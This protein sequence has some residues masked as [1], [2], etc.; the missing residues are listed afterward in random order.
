MA[1]WN[2]ALRFGLEV[3]AVVA[4]G[5]AAW[6]TSSSPVRW[7]AVVAIP[8]IAVTSWGVFNVVGDPSRSGRAPVEVPGWLRLTIELAVLGG[9]AVAL[10][11]AG[12][13]YL[14]LGL[15][16]LIVAHYAVSASRIRWLLNA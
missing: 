14:A 10:A 1:A 6:T 4:L 8:A 7:V 5:V 16:A 13:R 11:L 9:G 12:Q 2:L 3:G 15:A